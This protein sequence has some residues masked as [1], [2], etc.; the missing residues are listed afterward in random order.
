MKQHKDVLFEVSMS[1]EGAIAFLLVTDLFFS[2]SKSSVAYRVHLW[3]VLCHAV[4]LARGGFTICVFDWC[5][6]STVACGE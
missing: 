1:A 2:S 4:D 6:N 3:Y 5:F